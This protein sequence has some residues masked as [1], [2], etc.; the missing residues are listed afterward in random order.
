[1]IEEL[2]CYHGVPMMKK[3][4][5][6]AGVTN[7]ILLQ[8]MQG[9][10]YGLEQRIEGFEKRVKDEFTAVHGRFGRLEQDMGDVKVDIAHIND[11]L[12]RLYGHRVSMLGRIERL[13]ETVGIS[14]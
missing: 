9:M 5:K 10:R 7:L 4:P 6:P 3:P 2:P 12:Q 14:S 8:H 11:A 1:M 13:E